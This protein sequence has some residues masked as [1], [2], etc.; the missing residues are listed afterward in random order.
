MSTVGEELDLGKL[1]KLKRYLTPERLSKL[2][3]L[4]RHELET[5]IRTLETRKKQRK[6]FQMYPDDG[7]YAREGYPKHIHFMNATS[8][9]RELCFLAGNRVGKTITGSYLTTVLTTGLYPEWWEGRR[10]DRPVE[11][12][13]AGDNAKTVRD[14]IQT[15]L[16]G[17]HDARGT[18]MVPGELIVRTTPKAGVP[19]AIDTMYIK[20][21][22]ENGDH[23]GTSMLQFKSYDQGRIA[24]QGTA[25]QLIWLDEECPIE[26]YTECLTRTM[27]TQG[28]VILTFTPLTGLTPLV[29]SFLPGGTPPKL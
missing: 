8:K 23:D 21:H 5:L 29:L 28:L 16:L 27:T 6:F 3:D 11:A 13:A 19:D 22:D 17:P 12:W 4:K 25:R 14:I 10:F 9:Y 20:H 26:V 24:F 2:D 15:E 1:H 18:G 7:P